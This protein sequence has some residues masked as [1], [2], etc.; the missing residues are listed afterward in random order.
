MA[1]ITVDG[2][3]IDD[4]TIDGD[5]V[6]EITMDGDVVYQA[7]AIPDNVLLPE[8][9]D[10]DHFSYNTGDYEITTSTT[11]GDGDYALWN[12]N[13]NG[14]IIVS[15]PGDGLNRYPE[16]DERIDYYTRFETTDDPVTDF[17]L[18]DTDEGGGEVSGYAFQYNS[19]GSYIDIYRIDSA[20]PKDGD[21]PYWHVSASGVTRLTNSPSVDDGGGVCYRVEVDVES[22]D[23][24]TMRAFNE[25]GSEMAE[26]SANDT[27]YSP[28]EWGIALNG[29]P[30][31]SFMFDYIWV[32][33]SL[34][35]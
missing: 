25:G 30:E 18:V 34:D 15:M 26:A 10:L 29:R 7:S 3:D 28:E 33:E 27:T 32:R 23:D 6:N 9:G 12:S 31:Y 21:Q 11:C 24:L 1:P 16:M 35:G 19:R 17:T 5:V 2:L 13:D 20:D 4:A 8:P 22:N 14:G